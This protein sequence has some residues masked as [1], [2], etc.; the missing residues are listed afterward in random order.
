MARE[1]ANIKRAQEQL[2]RAE[3]QDNEVNQ[4][5][6]LKMLEKIGYQADIAA[7]GR[8]VLQALQRQP[9]DL[10]LMDIQMPEMDG[11]ETARK[12]RTLGQTARES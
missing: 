7:N 6:A 12:I 8:E 9:Y 5:V 4:M 1:I 11:F 3:A 2:H 10:I